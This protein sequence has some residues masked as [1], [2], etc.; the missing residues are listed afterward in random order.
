MSHDLTGGHIGATAGNGVA[1]PLSLVFA[2]RRSFRQ[3]P[4]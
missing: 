3:V 4:L 2:T 1:L